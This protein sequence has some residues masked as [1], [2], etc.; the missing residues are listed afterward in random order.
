MKSGFRHNF[1]RNYPRDLR[2]DKNQAQN[3]IFDEVMTFL[4]VLMST[5]GGMPLYM[6]LLCVVHNFLEFGMQ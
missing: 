2:I 1:I 6:W 5:T 4:G 3:F